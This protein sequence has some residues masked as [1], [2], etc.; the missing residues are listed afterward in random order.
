MKI[1]NFIFVAQVIDLPAVTVTTAAEGGHVVLTV[2]DTGIG[3]PYRDQSRVF[4]RFYRVEKARNSDKGGTGLGLSI[5]KGI[6]TLHNANY[7]VD[8][9]EGKGSTFWFEL[10]TA[11]D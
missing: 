8:S 5:V 9:K 4:E 1:F 7:G 11:K 10:K 3:I 2:A 6:L